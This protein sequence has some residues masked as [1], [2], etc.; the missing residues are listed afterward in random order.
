MNNIVILNNNHVCTLPTDKEYDFS[1]LKACFN[2]SGTTLQ[3]MVA[4]ESVEDN[5]YNIAR[6]II[7]DEIEL[8]SP[9]F[10]YFVSLVY[11]GEDYEVIDFDLDALT[12]LSGTTRIKRASETGKVNIVWESADTFEVPVSSAFAYKKRLSVSQKVDDNDKSFNK[13]S[14]FLIF[15][16]YHVCNLPTHL[17][18]NMH[19]MR[20]CFSPKG[21]SLQMMILVENE[22]DDVFDILYEEFAVNSE[23]FNNFVHRVYA[24]EAHD[25]IDFEPA[26]LTEVCGT[27]LLKKVGNDV[28]I[29]WDSAEFESTTLSSAAT[30]KYRWLENDLKKYLKSNA[31]IA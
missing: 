15:P 30:L 3:L 21:D 24:A 2:H 5:E 4:L 14:Q 1:V 20:A 10:K 27:I 11:C 8:D 13:K 17:E 31:K 7:V 6:D 26:N 22:R 29:D 16:N 19:I 28:C 9:L 12:V 23:E 18:Y 25:T